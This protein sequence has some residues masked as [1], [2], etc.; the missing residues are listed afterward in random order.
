MSKYRRKRVLFVCIGNACRSPMAEAIA[1]VKAY[2]VIDAFSAGLAPTGFVTELTKQTLKKNGCWVDDLESK[3][4]SPNVYEQVDLV[5]DMSGRPE[6]LAFRGHSN[7]TEWKIE[8][9]FGKDLDAHQRAFEKI[10]MRVEKLA[11]EYREELSWEGSEFS[12]PVRLRERHARR[13]P[14]RTSRVLGLREGAF[15]YIKNI[16]TWIA[17]QIAGLKGHALN[18]IKSW[19]AAQA[20]GLKEDAFGYI[21]IKTWIAALKSSNNLPR[22]SDGV[23]EK[24]NPRFEGPR[25][26][27]SKPQSENVIPVAS[28]KVVGNRRE[29]PVISPAPT[30]TLRSSAGPRPT[31]P[32]VSLRAGGGPTKKV[33]RPRWRLS[34]D[35]GITEV[36]GRK[37]AT[38]AIPLVIVGSLVG[39]IAF[40]VQSVAVQHNARGQ[41]TAS[42]TQKPSV[43]GQAAKP[44][45]P[46]S[47]TTSPG[48]PNS[49]AN[50]TQAQPSYVEPIPLE[51]VERIIRSLPEDSPKRLPRGTSAAKKA[52]PGITIK[53]SSHPVMNAAADGHS[54][55]TITNVPANTGISSA[56]KTP[57]QV[58]FNASPAPPRL[59][60]NIAQ[61]AIPAPRPSTD[62]RAIDTR[63]T[64]TPAN[65]IRTPEPES[66]TSPASAAKEPATPANI[67]GA[68]AIVTDPYPS[69]R[70]PNASSKKQRQGASLQL[71]HLLSRIEPAYPE[72]AKQRGIQGTVKLHAVIDRNGSVQSLQSVNGP[73]VLVAAAM[74]AV[75][76]WRFSET[77]LGGQSVETEEDINIVF[78]LSNPGIPNK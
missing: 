74:S 44:A 34:G 51:E 37:W 36:L 6:D 2:D 50:K 24:Q 75:R 43:L 19:I 21:K 26:P 23:G 72:D 69:L 57:Q 18:H 68:V 1:R 49:P 67:T 4:I 56:A 12:A 62:T 33:P 8:D 32:G 28:T 53:T 38:L 11:Q 3:G 16:K 22:S 55:N 30:P 65:D 39:L 71:G 61:P 5:I 17:A 41:M 13:W 35:R 7:V 45:A 10:R 20:A 78:R 73:P 47:V 31:A 52:S 59:E 54:T 14:Y 77:L 15:N 48:V 66:K 9:P 40:T 29:A 27:L 58:A 64:D 63:A 46:P 42:I 60:S 76:Q 25:S 70:I